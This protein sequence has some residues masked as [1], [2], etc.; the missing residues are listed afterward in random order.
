MGGVKSAR[1]AVPMGGSA[2]GAGRRPAGVVSVLSTVAKTEARA[3]GAVALACLM[4]AA[5][6]QPPQPTARH[7]R[8]GGKEHFAEGFY[9]KASPR[10]IGDGEEVPRGGGQYLVGRP[11][12]IAGRTYYPHEDEHYVGVGMA[13]WYGDA[14]HGR[15]TANGE[16]YD[17]MALSAAHP[18]MPLPSYARVTNLSNGYSVIVRVNDRGPYAAGRV[19]DVSSRVADVLDFKRMG[20]AH[21]KV[22][23]VGK[24]PM[25]GSDDDQLLATLRTDGGPASIGGENMVAEAA[26]P[27]LSLFGSHAAPPPPPPPPEPP[28]VEAEAPPPP[29]PRARRPAPE[30]EETDV[31][32]A[33]ETVAPRAEAAPLPPSRPYDLG[34]REA[35]AAR[36]APKPPLRG[37]SRALYFTP[38][39]TDPLSRLIR[40]KPAHAVSDDDE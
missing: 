18:T 40:T 3:V 23:Y 31:A 37:A 9:G 22:E 1:F 38:P 33:G 5:C 30:P 29:P 4:V 2:A 12:H 15:K 21:V 32:D 35:S 20:T 28:R 14:F 8:Q 34:L 36:T 7:Y 16:I 26:S 6:A 19:M 39:H 10:M 13:S 24:A 27:L 11:Y 17:K 25:E